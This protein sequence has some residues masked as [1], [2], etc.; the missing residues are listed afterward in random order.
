MTNPES[1]KLNLLENSHAFLKEA[2]VKAHLAISDTRQWQFAIL[3]LVQ[4]LE[5]SL[6]AAL[7]AI[8]PALIYDNLDN[9]KNTV[10]PLQALQRLANP[11]IGAGITFSDNDKKRIQHAIEVRNEMTHSQFELTG[12]YAAAKFF[13]L[14][15][16]VADFQR[17]HLNTTVSEIL[18]PIEFESLIQVRKLLDELV[19]RAEARIA[20]EK[21]VPEFIWPCPNC[22][23]EAF[24]IEDGLDICYVCSHTEPVTSCPQCSEPAYEHTIE[25][26]F[27]ELDTDYDEGRTIIR[28]AY[29]YDEFRA[30]QDCIAEIRQD[31]RRQREQDEFHR[32]EEE[33]YFRNRTN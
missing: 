32:L 31:I 12:E 8:H 5:L 21:I 22:G 3:N 20:E 23:E 7:N 19:L 33:Y 18:P 30:C 16:F 4:S 10:G 15:A 13:E 14:F 25:S 29:G 11:K 27:G 26:F 24:V 28:N 17:Q 9:P 2:V 6:K 1:L